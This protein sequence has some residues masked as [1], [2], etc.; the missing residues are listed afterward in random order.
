MICQKWDY[1]A[2]TF[3]VALYVA[4]AVVLAATLFLTVWE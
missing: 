3:I 2:L 4:G 1:Y